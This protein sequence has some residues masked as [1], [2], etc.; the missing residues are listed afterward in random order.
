MSTQE[1]HVVTGAFGYSGKYIARR[2]LERGKS[3][4]TITNRTK[5]ADPFEGR[6]EVRPLAFRNY[7][8][9]VESLR[10]AAVLYNTYWVRFNHDNFSHSEA[11]ENTLTLFA[12]AR[13]AGVQRV[14]HVSITNP[15]ED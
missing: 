8:S 2:L 4:R 13:E 1:L 7:P 3:V 15:S 11:I 6:V 14:V 9:L 10:G 12:A 5:A